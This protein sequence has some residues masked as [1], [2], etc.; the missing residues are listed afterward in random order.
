MDYKKEYL[1][2][3]LHSHTKNLIDRDKFREFMRYD[4]QYPYKDNHI[5]INGK[6]LNATLI[7]SIT[8]N[9]AYI[10]PEG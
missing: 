1:S 2:L 9:S 4:F 3:P 10:A 8:K 5:E 6:Y 7:N